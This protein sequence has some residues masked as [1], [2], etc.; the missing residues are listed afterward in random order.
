MLVLTHACRRTAMPTDE[1][2]IGVF[3]M[4][5]VE[6]ADVKKHPQAKLYPSEVITLMVVF[7]AKGGHYRAFYRWILFNYRTLFPNAPHYTRLLRLFRTHAHLCD[8][9][10]AAVS[11]MSIVDT[12]GIELIHPRREGRSEAQLGRT[13]KSNGRWIVGIKWV[14]LINQRGEIID[15]C[16]D[17]A[18]EHDN[19]FCELVTAYND[20]T[21]GFSDR[22]FRK[23]DTVPENF[24]YCAKGEWNDRYLIECVFRWMSDTF[25]AKQLYHRVD[26]YLEARLRSVAAAF[27]ILLKMSDYSYSMTWFEL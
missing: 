17:T 22:G 12:Y 9:F 6:L 27:N 14:V 15:W 18:N 3:C 24:W 1:L 4:I 8:R 10:L 20:K 19:T 13:G 11:T 2:I 23:R 26:E 7:S 5:D 21:I 25:D 16:W